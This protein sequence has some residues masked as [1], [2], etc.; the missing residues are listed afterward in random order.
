LYTKMIGQR[1]TIRVA[2]LDSNREHVAYE[3]SFS[4][5]D[6]DVVRIGRS[7][8]NDV[9]ISDVYVS[10]FHAELHF[11]EG[12]WE[13]RSL[14]RNGVLFSGRKIEDL[15]PIAEASEFQLGPSGSFIRL[16]PLNEADAASALPA[17]LT[18][19]VMDAA[20]LSA[21]AVDRMDVSRAVA[22]IADSEYFRKL[23]EIRQTREAEETAQK[24]RK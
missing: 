17:S 14:G 10:R 9:V 7:H 15:H 23:R 18:T 16:S 3:W 21:I 24:L 22:E 4:S 19:V 6:H 1:S 5:L 13:I 11:K 12:A 20:Q 8:E 2:L